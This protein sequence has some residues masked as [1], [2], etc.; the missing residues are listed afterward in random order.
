MLQWGHVVM[1]V[2]GYVGGDEN[3]KM[4]PKVKSAKWFWRNFQVDVKNESKINKYLDTAWVLV[5]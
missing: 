5:V 2:W 1:W 4:N 3:P